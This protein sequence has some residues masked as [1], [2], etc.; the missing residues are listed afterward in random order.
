[1]NKNILI[2]LILIFLFNINVYG[3]NIE[4]P[5][6][7]INKDSNQIINFEDIEVLDIRNNKIGNKNW[8]T[9]IILNNGNLLVGEINPNKTYD[10]YEIN[11]QGEKSFITNSK[12]YIKYMNEQTENF[13]TVK[14]EN[15]KYYLG[16][17]DKEFNV[18]Y[19]TIFEY[20]DNAFSNYSE[21]LK[22]KN[23]GYGVFTIEG[24]EIIS[25]IFDSIKKIDNNTFEGK[26]NN[27]SY[28]L[29]NVN[30]YYIN[31]TAINNV[32]NWAKDS[33][34][35]AVSLNFVPQNLQI[36]LN[37]YITRE[38]FCEIMLR[39]YEE[40][41][42][43]EIP[44]NIKNP[45]WDTNNK[46]VLKAYSMGI[47]SGKL[48]NKFEPN[49]YITREES[50]VI[51]SNLLNKMEYRTTEIYFSYKDENLMST[52]AKSSIQIVSNAGIMKGDNN[53][54]FNPKNNYKVVEAISTIMRL[55]NLK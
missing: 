6:F 54:N 28:I 38:E 44:T 37:E 49:S 14:Q 31:E 27:N 13:I 5:Y 40:K 36:K 18:I 51:L 46:Y 33:V 10:Y 9:A 47:V 3:N 39:L 42:G 11:K 41:T 20:K 22:L 25:P 43:F 32:D 15:E 50:A 53:N 1:M 48:E 26:Y 23:G 16:I 24:Q 2:I 12:Y 29:K 55:Y 21:I 19:D 45:F 4:Q 17:L 7:K 30:G 52:W 8:S 34:K 35:K